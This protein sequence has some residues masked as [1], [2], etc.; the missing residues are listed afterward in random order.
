MS[1]LSFRQAI[2]FFLSLDIWWGQDD[3]IEGATYDER[4]HKTK[5]GM[6]K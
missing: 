3:M 4:L 1:Q 6:R 5:L 2:L